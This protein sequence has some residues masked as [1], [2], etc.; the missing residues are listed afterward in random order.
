MFELTSEE[1]LRMSPV[2]NID[3]FA[4]PEKNNGG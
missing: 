4:A 2:L 1:S 3:V